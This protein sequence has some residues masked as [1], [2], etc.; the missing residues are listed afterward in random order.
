MSSSSGLPPNWEVRVSRS[1]G[2]NYYYNRVTRES[3]WEPPQSQQEASSAPLPSDQVRASHIL[4][5]HRD[6]RRPSSW[7]EENI[8]RSKEEAL[9]LIQKYRR[10]IETQAESFQDLAKIHSDCSSAKRGGDLGFFGRGAMQKP[11]EDATFGLEVNQMSEPIW[12]DSGVHII[13]R[14]A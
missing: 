2:I 11:F 14:T 9:D 1:R 8:T 12:T 3:R 4:V 7:K 6:S 13:L 5:K 10:L